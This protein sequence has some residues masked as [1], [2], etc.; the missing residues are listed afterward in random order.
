M[1]GKNLLHCLKYLLGSDKSITQ[2]SVNEQNAMHKYLENSKLIA[3]IGVFEGFNT[4]EFALRSP[5]DAIIYAID[6]FFKSSMGICYGE[7]IAKREWKRNKIRNKI[8]IIKGFSWDVESSI[9]D[10]IDFL[11]VDG[12]HTF[13]GVK[14]DFDIY[15]NKMALHGTIALHDARVFNTGWTN[16]DWGPVRLV[17][18]VVQ[19]N[20]EWKIVE[21]IDSLVFLQ[22]SA[23]V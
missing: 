8:K 12:D 3:E 22:R 11:F 20:N 2:T 21:E 14:K 6:P 16:H 4:R 18:E 9:P 7:I 13:D 1:K 19:K 17:K 10:K 23:V 15:K 5:N